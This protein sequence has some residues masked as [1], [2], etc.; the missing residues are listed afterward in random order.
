VDATD[1]IAAVCRASAPSSSSTALPREI[2]GSALIRA[3]DDLGLRADD[4]PNRMLQAVTVDGLAR[5]N[6]RFSRGSAVSTNRLTCLACMLCGGAFD[7]KVSLCFQSA[8]EDERRA[9]SEG[10]ATRFF[11]RDA[12]AVAAAAAK[13]AGDGG[14]LDWASDVWRRR[15][16]MHFKGM[17]GNA[18]SKSLDFEA[19]KSLVRQS[20]DEMSEAVLVDDGGGGHGDVENRNGRSVSIVTEDAVAGKHHHQRSESNVSAA[21]GEGV[22]LTAASGVLLKFIDSVSRSRGGPGSVHHSRGGSRGGGSFGS[23]GD[24]AAATGPSSDVSELKRYH[25]AR[26]AAGAGGGAAAAANASP[27]E[28][29]NSAG[30][31]LSVQIPRSSSYHQ[32]SPIADDDARTVA[33]ASGSGSRMRLTKEEE[34][35]V[36]AAAAAAAKRAPQ[37]K[38]PRASASKTRRGGGGDDSAN[39]DHSTPSNGEPPRDDDD[40]DDDD[41][42]PPPLTAEQRRRAELRAALAAAQSE[43]ILAMEVQNR[44]GGAEDYES[45]MLFVHEVGVRMFMYNIV[46]MLIVIAIVA[47]DASVCVWVMFHFGIV[48]GLSVVMVINIALACIV[49]YFV[50]KYSDRS[51]GKMHMEYGQHLVKGFSDTINSSALASTAN[52]LAVISKQMDA[53]ERN[54][55]ERRNELARA[56]SSLERATSLERG[57][58]G[59]LWGVD[60]DDVGASA[61]VASP[62][63]RRFSGGGE[64]EYSPGWDDA[65]RSPRGLDA[66]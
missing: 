11:A 14:D 61:G 10:Q 63:S 17:S 53:A 57:G 64:Y 54:M 41:K 7:A 47:A 43:T 29:R 34:A 6:K 35:E 28:R 62:A 31:T 51:K 66:V 20:L 22:E 26:R 9:L 59:A 25:A 38:T 18:S 39:D 15:C 32:L 12:F 30:E 56:G 4:I 13:S 8:D 24:L 49:G 5:A 1:A 37:N 44:D 36:A 16:E 33:A 52:Q 2:T 65:A 40:D 46:K 19:F 55:E 45:A 42:R 60:D 21:S 27:G 3:L 58:G 48:T 50:Y 23:F